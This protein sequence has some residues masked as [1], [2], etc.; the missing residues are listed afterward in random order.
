MTQFMNGS[1][2]YFQIGAVQSSGGNL[3]TAVSGGFEQ[4]GMSIRMV[5]TT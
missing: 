2:D 5:G 4:S 1:T 3:A